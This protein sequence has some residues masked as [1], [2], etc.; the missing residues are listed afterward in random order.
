MGDPKL[1]FV[2]DTSALMSFYEGEDGAEKVRNLLE[3]GKEQRAEILVPFI[4]PIEV[5]YI[6]TQEEGEE[7]ADLRFVALM[8]SPVRILSSINE[9][10]LIT[11]GRLKAKYSISLADALVAAHA[12]LEKAVLVHKDP[13]FL[14]LK[15][16]VEQE[17]LPLKN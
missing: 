13:E 11:A 1:R 15:E 12:L 7:T 10:F 14:L 8:E 17:V 6:T 4:V 3:L 9:P 2:L 16:E 5:Y